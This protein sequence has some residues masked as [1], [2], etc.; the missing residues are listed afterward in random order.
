VAGEFE[1]SGDLGGSGAILYG[2][3]ATGKRRDLA[4][5]S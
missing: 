4:T 2:D 5:A 3:A 1:P